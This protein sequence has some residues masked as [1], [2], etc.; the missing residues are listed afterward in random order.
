MKAAE[1]SAITTVRICKESATDSSVKLAA[2]LLQQQQKK[3]KKKNGQV[4]CSETFYHLLSIV[5]TD[6]APEY[7]PLS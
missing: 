1:K 7:H 5:H 6:K 3:N 4:S 2:N